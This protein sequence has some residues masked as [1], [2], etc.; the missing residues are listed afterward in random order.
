MWL[1][2]KRGS[3]KLW[4]SIAWLLLV[5]LVLEG[6]FHVGE[7]IWG[8]HDVVHIR[9]ADK[10]L[11]Y[12]L[13]PNTTSVQQGIAYTINS[14]G[15]RDD[16]Y[17]IER[18]LNAS[19]Q[20]TTYRIIV[21][22]D[23][24]TFGWGVN[25]SQTFPNVLERMLRGGQADAVQGPTEDAGQQ[26]ID[27][28]QQSHQSFEVLNFGVSGYGTEQEVEQ[29]ATKALMYRPDQV[30]V[31]YV[32]NDP[33][34]NDIVF[35]PDYYPSHLFGWVYGKTLLVV[36]KIYYAFFLK[37]DYIHYIHKGKSFEAVGAAFDRLAAL[38]KQDNFDVTVVIVP[39]FI[40]DYRW[41]DVHALVA[42]RARQAGLGVLDLYALNASSLGP[43]DPYHPDAAGHEEI[44]R[45]IAHDVFGLR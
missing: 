39:L 19:G 26:T 37:E 10:V 18:P 45:M 29:L 23:S 12:E 38:A 42:G 22:G 2:A 7:T 1:K 32:L 40:E 16:A 21:L 30:I 44:A 27:S 14:Q 15:F 33:G 8:N 11:M 4:R 28:S 24:V 35:R 25:S 43:Q 31:A 3:A 9:S 34:T 5:F 20:P 36:R 6:C 17:P 41:Q 13:N